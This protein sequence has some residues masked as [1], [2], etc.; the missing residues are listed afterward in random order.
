MMK[1]ACGQ[2]FFYANAYKKRITFS[3]ILFHKEKLFLL[4]TYITSSSLVIIPHSGRYNAF[5]A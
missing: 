5:L 2:V 3:V 4:F 1:S